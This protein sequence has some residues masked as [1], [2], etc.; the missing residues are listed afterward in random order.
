MA[1]HLQGIDVGRRSATACRTIQRLLSDVGG[2]PS[3]RQLICK[4][5]ANIWPLILLQQQ[6]IRRVLK[7]HHVIPRYQWGRPPPPPKEQGTVK[8]G[9]PLTTDYRLQNGPKRWPGK[10]VHIYTSGA[11][12][13]LIQI[14]IISRAPS[15]ARLP[16]IIRPHHTGVCLG[17][18][19]HPQGA[20][21][22]GCKDRRFKSY[23][24]TT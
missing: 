8:S 16:D 17:E 10:V 18:Q 22:V 12:I 3:P 19:R 11:H 24:S 1:H 6:T 23:L 13:I 21:L 20:S 15:V 4:V 5:A 7:P 14:A 2:K 9:A